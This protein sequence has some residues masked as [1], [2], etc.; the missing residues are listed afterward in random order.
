MKNTD[1][2]YRGKIKSRREDL[3][4]QG[5]DVH[6]TSYLKFLCCT[7]EVTEKVPNKLVPEIVFDLCIACAERYRRAT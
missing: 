1:F 7:K 2:V 3:G 5:C 4:C 6:P